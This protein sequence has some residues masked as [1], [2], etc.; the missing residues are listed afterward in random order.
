L[1]P[2]ALYVVIKEK[3]GLFELGDTWLVWV[4]AFVLY[5]FFY[6]WN[7]R[8]GHE[9]NLLWASHVVHHSSEEYNLTTALRQTG[10]GF[11]SVFFYLPMAT[12]HIG[13]MGWFELFFV[14]PSNHR[15]HHAQ[16]DVYID[17][18]YGGVFIIWD[19]LFGTYQEELD[20]QPVIFGITGA[21]KSWNPLW[22]NAQVYAQLAH[23]AW[24]TPADVAEKFPL[25]KVDLSKF[26]KFDI[27]LPTPLKYYVVL[28]Y[29]Q[30]VSLSFYISI[31]FEQMTNFQLA[32]VATYMVV[33]LYGI[34][35][36]MEAK[37]YSGAYEWLRNAVLLGIATSLPTSL[38]IWLIVVTVASLPMLFLGRLEQEKNLASAV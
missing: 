17:K 3:F 24:H 27:A 26:Q 15:A 23:D 14:T 19:R 5:D 31:Y 4:V 20:D 9:V 18:N 22:V 7:H 30:I 35:A 21:V 33:G 36:L 13:K 28:Q 11:L 8:L 6:Y 34:G 32:Y 2:F 38:L 16:N 1:I 25:A 10:T 37:R 12:R 29:I